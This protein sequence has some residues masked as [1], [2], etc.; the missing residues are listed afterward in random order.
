[1]GIAYAVLSL[2]AHTLV[3]PA[4]LARDP[5]APG[6]FFEQSALAIRIFP[7]DHNLWRVPMELLPNFPA[8]VLP[9]GVAE[10]TLADIRRRDPEYFLFRDLNSL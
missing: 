6:W 2:W 10:K 1:L 9:E 5:H 4:R 7:L 3:M 8:D